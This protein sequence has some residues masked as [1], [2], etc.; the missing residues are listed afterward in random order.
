MIVADANLEPIPEEFAKHLGHLPEKKTRVK[1]ASIEAL[2]FYYICRYNSKI[3]IC[4]Y[5]VV[6]VLYDQLMM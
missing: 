6:E 1:G 4:T 2:F 3:L 5:L